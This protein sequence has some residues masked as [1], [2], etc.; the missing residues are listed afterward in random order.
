MGFYDTVSILPLSLKDVFNIDDICLPEYSVNCDFHPHKDVTMD[1][2][3]TSPALSSTTVAYIDSSTAN[4]NLL[5]SGARDSFSIRFDTNASFEIS[6]DK[7]DFVGPIRPLTN[8]MLGGLANG[9]AI[10]GIGTVIWKF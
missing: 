1:G 4:V 9:V 7:S 8:H 5:Y 2:T 3:S 6:F 10:E